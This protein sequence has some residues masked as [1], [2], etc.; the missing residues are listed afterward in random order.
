MK[1]IIVNVS[2]AGNVVIDAVGFKGKGCAKATEQ[3]EIMLG[4]EAKKDTKPEYSLPT[5]IA[6]AIEARI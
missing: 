6:A 1:Q 2:P 5:N 3:I 4:G